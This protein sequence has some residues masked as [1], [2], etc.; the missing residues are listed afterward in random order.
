[1][2]YNKQYTGPS[3]NRYRDSRQ[4]SKENRQNVMAQ[5]TCYECSGR[6]YKTFPCLFCMRIEC[7]ICDGTGKD[8]EQHTI[9]Y[10]Y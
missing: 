7:D 6:G 8:P 10:F 2:S 4:K 5:Q 3:P 1:M 9:R